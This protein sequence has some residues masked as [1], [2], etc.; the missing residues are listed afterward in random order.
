MEPEPPKDTLHRWTFGR[1]PRL[2]VLRVT[3]VVV[4]SFVVFRVVFVPI[5][6]TGDSMSPTYRN[7]QINL[8]NR[9]AYRLHPPKRG[10]VV[11]VREAG[12]SFVILKR[13]IGLPGERIAVHAGV[14]YI[15][16]KPLEEP[17]LKSTV[18]WAEGAIRLDPDEYY[19]VGDNRRLSFHQAVKREHIMGRVVF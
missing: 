12:S 2:T 14:V 4:L 9:Q 8:I 15:D 17:Y 6:V 13:I 7:G 1:D 5:R 18:R 10:D 3:V 16:G 11:A 19:V